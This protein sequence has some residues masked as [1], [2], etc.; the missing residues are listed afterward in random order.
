[1]DDIKAVNIAEQ[2]IPA[3]MDYINEGLIKNKTEK[4]DTPDVDTIE[5]VNN[6]EQG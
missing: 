6:P 1:M 5:E 2:I 3:L 4:P